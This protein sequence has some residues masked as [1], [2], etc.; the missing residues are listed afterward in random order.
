MR[1]QMEK[2][3]VSDQPQAT[4]ENAAE[5]LSDA[6]LMS[7]IRQ[8]EGEYRRARAEMETSRRRLLACEKEA[9]RRGMK[10]D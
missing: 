7:V 4:L 3:T 8:A 10:I 5:T 9:Y 2:N 1:S 6:E